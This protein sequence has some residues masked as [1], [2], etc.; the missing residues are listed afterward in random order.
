MSKYTYKLN[1]RVLKTPKSFVVPGT[2]RVV[3]LEAKDATD[4]RAVA[5]E[6]D[7]EALFSA[8]LKDRNKRSIFIRVEK[9][10]AQAAKK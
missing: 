5:T 4:E 6:A 9:A 3:V 2:N 8:G 7:L 1:P 10:S